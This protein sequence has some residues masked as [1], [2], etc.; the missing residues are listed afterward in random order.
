MTIEVQGKLSFCTFRF[1][2]DTVKAAGARSATCPGANANATQ[3]ERGSLVDDSGELLLSETGEVSGATIGSSGKLGAHV[4]GDRKVY[5]LFVNVAVLG[6]E[7][8]T[9]PIP[10]EIYT[11]TVN[12]MGTAPDADPIQVGTV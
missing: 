9:K 3:A 12:I 8:N 2:D 4:A 5:S 10:N 11:G 6:R 7:T 1:I